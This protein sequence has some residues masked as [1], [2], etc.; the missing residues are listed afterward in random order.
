MA[1]SL[2]LGPFDFEPCRVR[3][4]GRPP[5]EDWEGP[6]CFALWCQRASP[7]WIG[8]MLNA[9]DD[10]FGEVFY[11]LCEGFGIS[12]EMIQRYKSVA[13]RVPAQNRRANLS[14]ST[15]AM[16]ARL[17]FDQQKSA[18]SKAEDRGWTSDDLRRYLQQEKSQQNQA[19]PPTQADTDPNLADSKDEP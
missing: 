19:P 10:K 17:P 9:G 15:H 7:W 6:F 2:K 14:W 1:S 16:V 18:L 5:I 13:R 3:V 12:A 4:R 11:Q 8:D